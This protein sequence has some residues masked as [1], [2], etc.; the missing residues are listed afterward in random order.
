[1][2]TVRIALLGCGTVGT[3]VARI[4]LEDRA[5]LAER[6][7]IDFDLR[8]VV[9]LDTARPRSAGVPE[10]NIITNVD[11][12]VEAGEVEIVVELFGGVDLPRAVI[13]RCLEAGKHVVTA[14]KALLALHGRELFGLARSRGVCI[15]FEASCAGGIPVIRALR[16]G[17]I[18]NRVDAIYGI[19]NGTA[20]YILTEM[21]QHGKA[22]E[23]ALAEAQEAG[24]AEADPSL[25][26]NGTDSA[27]KLA[28]MGS[29][30][31]TQ[32]VDF[33]QIHVEGIDGVDLADVQFA[34]QLGYEMKLLAI[35]E[36]LDEGISLRVH[37]AL[38][39]VDTP[40]AAVHGPFNA[41]SAFGHA[42]GHTLYYGRGAGQSP[43]ASAIV[44]DLVDVALGN[45]LRTFRDLRVLPDQTEPAVMVPMADI[46]SRYYL[47]FD[48]LDRPGTLGRITRVLG[49][50]G[51]SVSAAMQ[52]EEH[53]GQQ[54]PLV[55]LTHL[56]R[57]GGVQAAIEAIDRFDVIGDPTRII[58]IVEPRAERIER[59]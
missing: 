15:A 1:M 39:R 21:R 32:Q 37:P 12:V 25:D 48:A 30:V 58:R 49:E 2:R 18:A 17:L 53:A 42:V 19:L 6:T 47:R 33:D 46:Q 43:T 3:G 34:R 36:R 16:E 45:G 27:H 54:V 41:V 29:L 26:V 35:G 40:L 8:Y 22:Y 20:N 59:N 9:D 24:Y 5:M 51:I 11:P 57:E 31:F 28:I 50:Q 23:T 7:G 56:S 14:N 4:L 44:A 13:G 10:E 52:H 38:V 55:I